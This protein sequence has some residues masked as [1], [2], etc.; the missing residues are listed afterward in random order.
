MKQLQCEWDERLGYY[1]LFVSIDKEKQ[2]IIVAKRKV[3][4]FPFIKTSMHLAIEL[5][6]FL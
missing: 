4:P 5:V 2:D 6:I 3:N 1:V